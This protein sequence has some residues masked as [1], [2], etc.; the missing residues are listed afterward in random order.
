MKSLR[1]VAGASGVPRPTLPLLPFALQTRNATA[2]SSL[3]RTMSAAHFTSSTQFASRPLSIFSKRQL[4]SSGPVSQESASQS[5]EVPAPTPSYIVPESFAV[6][7]VG[8][9]QYKV[10]KGDTIITERLLVD[11]GETI[12][13]KKVL[14]VGSQNF[15]AIGQPLLTEAVVEAVVEEQTRAAKVVVFKFKRRKNHRRTRGHRQDITVLR[16][17]NVKLG[18]EQAAPDATTGLSTVFGPTVPASAVLP[19]RA[20]D[21]LKESILS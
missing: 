3:L 11:V 7:Y 10:S 4:H 14:M 5:A 19:P 16:I 8:G 2:G 1:S 21:D 12:H 15:T 9:R 20:S 6:V 18:Y 17:S 13:L